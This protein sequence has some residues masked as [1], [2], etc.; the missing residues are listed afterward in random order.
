M[1]R[2]NRHQQEED[3]NEDD[4]WLFESVVAF[5]NSPIWTIPIQHFIENHCPSR[6]MLWVIFFIS[7]DNTVS[8]SGTLSLEA[9]RQTPKTPLSI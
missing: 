1:S 9:L 6:F 5:L 8:S 4:E 2:H 3:V 7:S